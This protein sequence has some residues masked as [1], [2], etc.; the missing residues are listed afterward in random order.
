MWLRVKARKEKCLGG[1][2]V[3]EDTGCSR[4][5]LRFSSRNPDVL[6]PGEPMLS[7]DLREQQAHIR[8]IRRSKTLI[9]ISRNTL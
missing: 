3:L 4:G 6:V 9:H 5:G 8:Y 2:S 7:V 1:G